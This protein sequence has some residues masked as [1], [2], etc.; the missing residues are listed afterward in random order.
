MQNMD[1]DRIFEALRTYIETKD[2]V[3]ARLLMA[4]FPTM[5]ED[6][7]QALLF[8]LG[9]APDGF[10]IPLLVGLL[11]TADRE[12]ENQPMV[13][14]LLFSKALDNPELL[15][16]LLMR[17]VKP[18]HRMVLVEVA[19]EIKL[20]DTTPIMLGILNEERDEK[21]LRS[22]VIALGMIGDPSATTPISEY[23]Y[24]GSVELII[25]AIHALGMLSTPTAIQRLAE[26]M[27]SDPDLDTLIMDVFKRSQ[28]PEAIERINDALSAQLAYLRNAAKKCLVD[29][30]PKTVPVLIN[31]LRY[32]DPDLLIHS[33]NVLGAIGDESAISP[34]RKL[35]HNQP[36]DANVRFAA[37]EA[38]GMLPVAKGAFA[39]AQGLN[40]PVDNVR[41]AA[42]SAINHNYNT[43]L[44]A[45]IKNM[46]RDEDPANRPISRTIMDTECDTI[47]LD[48]IREPFF[49]DFAI[50]YLGHQAHR[51]IQNHFLKLM[52]A[53][54]L[55]D[56]AE[57]VQGPT[58][59]APRKTL[60]IFAVD[61]S[62]M[63]LNIYRSVL[64][65]LNCEPILFEFPAEAIRQVQEVKPDLLFTDLN[66][67]DISGVELTKAVRKHFPK[68]A[69]PI[70]MVTTQ[71]ECQDNDAAIKAGVNDIL[72]KPFNEEKL[73]AVMEKYVKLG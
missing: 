38:L 2:L 67:P 31:N 35:L 25:A 64:H 20:E 33:L 18:S 44:A 54:G 16:Q 63:I 55:E 23:L 56:L 21:V 58:T 12:D 36:K 46:I 65:N 9:R 48:V 19:G 10:V 37:Y 34:I 61:D 57:A 11:A 53:N 72:N 42:A 4:Q 39:L 24:S 32:Y 73:R 41:A 22:T 13:R 71:N 7:Q 26:K 8:E 30:G 70:I 69:L 3:K 60:R 6:A 1:T 45:G 62:K 27:G 49:N 5:D 15:G 51:D 43:V 29:I 52:R 50:A 68:E 28:V 14:E 47:F 66:M 59:L 40:D 17:E